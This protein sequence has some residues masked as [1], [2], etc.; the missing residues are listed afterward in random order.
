MGCTFKVS[1]GNTVPFSSLWVSSGTLSRRRKPGSLHSATRAASVWEPSHASGS[2]D[3]TALGSGSRDLV[4]CPA[5]SPTVALMVPLHPKVHIFLPPSPQLSPQTSWELVLCAQSPPSQPLLRGYHAAEDT[6]V[7]QESSPRFAHVR[8]V[9]RGIASGERK[10]LSLS[11]LTVPKR[12]QSELFCPFRSPQH[13]S[14][15]GGQPEH[16][17]SCLI[18]HLS[19][20]ADPTSSLVPNLPPFPIFFLPQGLMLYP[21]LGL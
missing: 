16:V 8:S 21:F 14:L 3:H 13:A 12:Q 15:P 2:A 9:H 7:S 1:S 20:I 4:V 11:S 17:S 19:K 18:S 5:V 6:R 10:P